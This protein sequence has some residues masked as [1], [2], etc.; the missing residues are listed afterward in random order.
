AA[1]PGPGTPSLEP[2]MSSTERSTVE[3]AKEQSRYLRGTLAAALDHPLQPFGKDDGHILKFHGVYQQDDR[4]L[5]AERRHRRLDPDWIFMVRASIPGGVLTPEQYLVMD[6]LADEVGDGTLRITTRQGIQWHHTRKGGLRPLLRTL[7]DHLVTTLGACGDVVR[8][9]MS[10][11][12]PLP[13]REQVLA[14]AATLARHFRPRTQA[15]YE[16]WINGERAVSAEVSS[17]EEPVYGSAYLPR[18]FKIAFAYPGDNCVDVYSDDL[19]IVP[20]IEDEVVTGFT[21]LVGGGM[22]RSHNKPDTFPRL[23]D[24]LCRVSPDELVEVAEA[25][26]GIQRDYG[27]RADRRHARLK[28]LIEYWGLADF[29]RAVER[30]LGRSLPQ[31]TPLTWR[32]ADDHLG[33]HPQPDGRWF[34]GLAVENGRIADRDGVRLRSGLR[35]VVEELRPGIRLTPEQSIILTDL[36]AD[37]RP[38]VKAVLDTH[39]IPLPHQVPVV[40]RQSMACVALPTCGL[41]VTDAERALPRVIRRLDSELTELGLDGQAIRVRMT[42]CPNGCARP[43]NAEIGLVGRR[44][45]AYD[46]YLGGSHLGDRLNTLLAENVPEGQL[47]D[48]LRPALVA[49]RDHRLPDEAFGDFRHRVGPEPLRMPEATPA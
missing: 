35:A 14:H 28:Y 31:P 19:G 17:E 41:A 26:V 2:A 5:R 32:N 8:N 45:G 1:L 48:L 30:R 46:V 7:S 16:V 15:Y 3:V 38:T 4:D 33:W 47:V 20:V 42:G 49:W 36:S 9:V 27:E 13:G 44:M 37:A 39:A 25:I 29:R 6:R 11:P 10:C 18:K 43:Y 21:L 40:I 22:G 24:P 12:A 34:L 23:A